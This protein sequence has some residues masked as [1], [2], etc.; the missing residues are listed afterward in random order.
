MDSDIQMLK[1]ISTMV[2][3]GEDSRR[4]LRRFGPDAIPSAM[5]YE[6][7]RQ[8]WTAG[9]DPARLE[10]FPWPSWPSHLGANEIFVLN[11]AG[12]CVASSNAGKAASF[13]GS[14]YADRDY[15]RQAR[16]GLFPVTSTQWA[17][18]A[19]L[20]GLYLLDAGSWTSC[21][22]SVP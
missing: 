4:A 18:P 12:D 10:R 11:A 21:S 20:P 8:R 7:R 6:T 9:Q 2:A 14:N 1:G 16:A 13:V 22:S 5:A 19:R 17:A 15:F 3:N